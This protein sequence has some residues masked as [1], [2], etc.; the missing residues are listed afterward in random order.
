M[1]ETRK[2][3]GPKKAAEFAGALPSDP[4]LRGYLGPYDDM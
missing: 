4:Y 3:C 1:I 2:R